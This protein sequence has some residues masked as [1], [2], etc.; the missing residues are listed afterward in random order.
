[1]SL[2]EEI[3]ARSK[4]IHTD[5]Y[6]MSIGE[7]ANLYRDRELD[8]QPEFQRFFRWTPLQ[9][10]K[11]IESLLLG[12]PIPSIFV[13]QR[14]A[15]GVWDVVDGLQ[16][17]STI[18]EFM[19]L[20]RDEKN[21]VLP[22]TRLEATDYLPSLANKVW[23]EE[24]TTKPAD[25]PVE[26]EAL[27]QSQRLII[28]RTKLAINIVKRESAADTKLELFHR[29]NSLGSKLSD[30]EQLTV[31]CYYRIA[32][33]TSG[34]QIWRETWTSRRRQACQTPSWRKGLTWNWYGD[35]L[36][37]ATPR[38]LPTNASSTSKSF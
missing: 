31:F 38:R 37:F 22:A 33:H 28:K 29:L 14:S 17:L 13:A 15:D 34:R 6:P 25:S 12:I 2:Q 20:L 8:L 18:F 26:D 9:K 11:L 1:M 32:T 7:L 24:V 3:D 10:S 19:G 36:A 23:D 4:E 30:Q 27:S 35:S 16:R 5:A 21:V